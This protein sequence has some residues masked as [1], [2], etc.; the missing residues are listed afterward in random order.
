MN[1]A[2]WIILII[3]AIWIGIAVKVAFFGGFGKK[4]ALVPWRTPRCR[5]AER[6]GSQA[7]EC[8]HGLQQGELCRLR[9]RNR[10]ARCPDTDYSRK[11]GTLG[12]A[13]EKIELCAQKQR[14]SRIPM[15]NTGVMC[16]KMPNV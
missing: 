6:R 2:S 15:H 14:K 7:A 3:I 5:G 11:S 8:L 13:G 10:Q 4:G 9:K 12:L 1:I 16:R